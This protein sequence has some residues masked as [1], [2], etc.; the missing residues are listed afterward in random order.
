LSPRHRSTDPRELALA[1]LVRTEGGAFLDALL[2]RDLARAELDERSAALLARLAYGVEA[3]RGR[4]DWTLASLAGRDLGSLDPEVRAALRIGWFQILLLDRVPPHAAVDTSVEMAK[5]HRGVG[6]A[7]LVNAVLRRALRQGE[8]AF[9]SLEREP[10]RSLAVRWSHPEWLVER[11]IA[12]FGE[13]RAASLLEANNQ[14]APN[15]VR[16][17]RR[18]LSRDEALADL[19]SRG[20]PARA[21]GWTA[22]AIVVEAPL[23]RIAAVP[24]ASSQGEASQ[25]V[26]SLV[27]AHPGERIADVCAAPG[28]KAEALAERMEQGL[29]LAA[30]VSARSLARL[31][32]GLAAPGHQCIVPVR[33]DATQPAIR[34]ESMDA[35]LLDAPCS[36][37]G[38]LRAHPEIR[39]RRQPDDIAR[40]AVLQR[41]MLA[42]SARL[43]RPGGRLVYATCTLMAEENEGVIDELLAGGEWTQEDARPSLPSSAAQLVDQRG[44]LRTSPDR[45]GL[46]GFYAAILRRVRRS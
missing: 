2:G 10:A 19:L 14:P 33:V 28:G 40:L 43:V 27:D 34:A 20:V 18:L 13:E 31:R 15:V 12:A 17:N 25:L 5:V 8:R 11:W 9:P 36:G 30:D 6:A 23:R 45:G 7:R 29:V 39:W 35:V 32:A 22:D 4:L 3:W 1:I 38:T 37:L 21:G 44:A 24:W 46:D 41:K 16:V 26:A 42:A